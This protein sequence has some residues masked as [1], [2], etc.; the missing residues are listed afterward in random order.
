MGDSM[1]FSADNLLTGREVWRTSLDQPAT[2]FIAPE[3]WTSAGL[4]LTIGA[5]DKLH[6]YISGSTIDSIPA[7]DPALIAGIHI[8][9]RNLSDVLTLNYAGNYLDLTIDR[10]TVDV[11]RNNAFTSATHI[12]ID[13]GALN[14]NG[15]SSNIGNLLVTNDGQANFAEI[16]NHTTTVTS[17]VLVA[18]SIECDTLVIGAGSTAAGNPTNAPIA[19]TPSAAE[20]QFLPVDGGNDAIDAVLSEAAMPFSASRASEDFEQSLLATDESPSAMNFPL[21]RELGPE[22]NSSLKELSRPAAVNPEYGKRNEE[23][24]TI[25]LQSASPKT[26]MPF[27]LNLVRESLFASLCPWTPNS[28]AIE[29]RLGEFFAVPNKQFAAVIRS[30]EICPADKP[31][32]TNGRSEIRNETPP[33]RLNIIANLVDARSKTEIFPEREA[34]DKQELLIKK[35][36]DDLCRL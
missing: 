15:H 27:A 5:D 29:T 31:R 3:D 21:D 8:A 9:G 30:N 23:E 35:T 16:H 11:N 6:A 17:G 20:N 32:P 26:E 33:P 4:N 14:M 7:H 1:Y 28:R 12:V 10:A 36:L 19:A 2:L 24:S 25:N 22:V 34:F 18:N 13:G